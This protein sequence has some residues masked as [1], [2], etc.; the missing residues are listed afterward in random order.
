MIQVC[1]GVVLEVEGE[2]SEP[3]VDP[4]EEGQ[5]EGEGKETDAAARAGAERVGPGRKTHWFEDYLLPL[6][7]HGIL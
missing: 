4:E 5:Q 2:G 7:L 6:L 3:L 1:D